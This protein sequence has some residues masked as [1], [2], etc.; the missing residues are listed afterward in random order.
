M[1][2]GPGG[3]L[4]DPAV[5]RELENFVEVWLH[6]DHLEK[7]AENRERQN[8]ILGF[9]T[10]PY[11]VIYDPATKKTLRKQAFTMIVEDFL[12]FLRGE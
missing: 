6:F 10:N 3:P 1:M 5:K 11:W 4:R 12:K 7:G 8:E 2:E 9:Q